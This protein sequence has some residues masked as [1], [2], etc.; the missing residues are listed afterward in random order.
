MQPSPPSALFAQVLIIIFCISAFAVGQEKICCERL[1]ENQEVHA[2]GTNGVTLH[3]VSA[4]VVV[5]STWMTF[6]P[7]LAFTS[8]IVVSKPSV[9]TSL[10]RNSFEYPEHSGLGVLSFSYD[11]ADFPDSHVDSTARWGFKSS[12]TL[13]NV[14]VLQSDYGTGRKN[15]SITGIR[16]KFLAQTVPPSPVGQALAFLNIHMDSIA[17]AK[18]QSPPAMKLKLGPIFFLALGDPGLFFTAYHE[19]DSWFIKHQ[20]GSGDCPAGCTEHTKNIYRIDATGKVSLA[21][22]RHFYSLCFPMETVQ[23]IR[24]Q[25]PLRLQSGLFRADGREVKDDQASR[26]A[27]SRLFP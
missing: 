21:S 23:P 19:G 12:D 18:G 7:H 25:I 26:R 16:C 14:F 3:E 1:D 4:T 22:S 5:D 13:K 17:V 10:T 6:N 8:F 24:A 20:V 2:S 27:G 15:W 11:P 9:D